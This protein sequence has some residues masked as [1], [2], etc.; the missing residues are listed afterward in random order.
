VFAPNNKNAAI[1]MPAAKVAARIVTVRDVAP[2]PPL[3]QPLR[4][5]IH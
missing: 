1:S 2:P 4:I 5:A 3:S